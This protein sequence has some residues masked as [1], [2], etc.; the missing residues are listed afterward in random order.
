MFKA[1]LTPVNAWKTWISGNLEPSGRLVIDEGA[2]AALI[3]PASHCLLLVFAKLRASLD[4]QAIQSL[5]SDPMAVRLLA[6][7][8]AYDA[9]DAV[10]IAGR[11][12]N[13]MGTILG[14]DARSAMIHRDDSGGACRKARCGGQGVR[15]VATSG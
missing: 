13:E 2:L 10:K 11:K 9:A 1:S 7:G 15:D 5:C 6:N 14:Y 3:N 12:T 4:T 8:I